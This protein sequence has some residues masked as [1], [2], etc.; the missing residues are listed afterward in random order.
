VRKA[1][2]SWGKEHR[3]VEAKNPLPT[4][5][6]HHISNKFQLPKFE[7]NLFWSFEIRNWSLFG[8]WN[9]LFGILDPIS[10]S[11]CEFSSGDED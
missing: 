7:K 2:R 3:D 6:R 11:L 8:I 5:G 4:A 1:Q 9:L 10:Y